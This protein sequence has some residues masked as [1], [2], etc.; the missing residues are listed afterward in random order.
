MK[1]CH[2]I[3]C[4][5]TCIAAAKSTLC[6]WCVH[7]ISIHRPPHVGLSTWC[8]LSVSVHI[9]CNANY[10][11]F[12]FFIWWQDDLNNTRILWNSV[13]SQNWMEFRADEINFNCSALCGTHHCVFLMRSIQPFS[14]PSKL[15]KAGESATSAVTSLSAD[16]FRDFLRRVFVCVAQEVFPLFLNNHLCLEVYRRGT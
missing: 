12:Y 11:L 3:C 5:V 4:I 6:K 16:I 13:L 15:V 7:T 10:F 2:L 14:A 9:A 1:S 8:H